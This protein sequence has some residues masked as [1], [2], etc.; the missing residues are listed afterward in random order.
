MALANNYGWLVLATGNKSETATGYTTIYGDMAGAFAPLK[1]VLKTEVY[2]LCRHRNT[3]PGGP[4]IP[5][6][7]LEKPPSAE[8]RPGQ[9]DEDSLPPYGLL[10]PILRAYV[11]QDKSLEEIVR[12]GFDPEM[13]R[14]VITLVHRS[15]YK[16]R[17]APPGVK[18]SPRAFGRDRRL[19]I[20]NR[21][22]G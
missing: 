18:V 16:R 14:R 3:W 21:Y 11:E 8:L 13:V 20:A 10:D 15:E 22:V 5:E 7:I 1:D 12:M 2:A 17:Q 4:V 9:K 6:S 19:P